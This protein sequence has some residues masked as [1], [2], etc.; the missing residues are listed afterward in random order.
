MDNAIKPFGFK[1]RIGYMFGDFGNDFTFILSSMFLMKFYTDVM[2]VSPAIVGLLMMT[3]R[4]VDAFTDVMMGQIVDRSKTTKKGKYSPWIRRMMGPVAVASFL[5][6]AV[7]FKD[8]PMNFKIFWMFFTYILWGSVCYTGINIPYGSMA[9]AISDKPE[10]RTSLSTW[11]SIGATL[12]ATTIAVVLPLFVYYTDAAGNSVFSGEKMMWAALTCSVLAV[13]CY[14]LCYNL[15]TERVKIDSVNEKFSLTAL[16]KTTVSNRSLVGIV[17]AAWML[18]IAQLTLS[19]M[20]NYIYPNYFNNIK[21]MAIVNLLGSVTTLVISTFIG[22]LSRK[23]GKKELSIVGS[24][25]GAG[26]LLTAFLLH[27][28]S[29]GTWMV[30][31]VTAYA[32]LSIFNIIVWAMITDVIDDV[33][34]QQGVRRDGTVYSVYSFARKLGQAASSGLTGL[35]LGA[36]GYSMETAREQAVVD[37]IYNM[38][39]M[40]P[41]IAFIGMA[42]V[43]AFVYPLSKN[44]VENNAATLAEKRNR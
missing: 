17:L 32:G 16:I 28:H 40:V 38:T 6:Y 36:I 18:L 1:D 29:I 37:G 10:D 19:G 33:E 5:M 2:E 8:M 23:F 35:L 39:T 42:L 34:V 14:I 3:A 7:W 41:A 21:V 22:P 15:T 11:R 26:S 43:L 31:Y 27:T 4:F 9:S 20:G 44:K 12:A 25:M 30:L 24:L 13:V